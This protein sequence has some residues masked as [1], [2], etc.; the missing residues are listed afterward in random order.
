MS[1]ITPTVGRKVW[2]FWDNRQTEPQDATIIKVMEADPSALVNLHVVHPDTGG[3]E[4]ITRVRAGDESTVWPHYRWMPYQKGQAAKAEADAAN[5]S[6]IDAE[7][8]EQAIQARGSKGPRVTQA[9]I[10]ANIASE[11]Y[12]TAEDGVR[13]ADFPMTQAKLPRSLSLLTICVLELRNGFNVVGMSACASPENF[14][15]DIG[16]QYAYRDAVRQVWPLLGFRLMD[17]LA[18]EAWEQAN[19]ANPEPRSG[20]L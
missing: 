10:E 18:R 2:F 15:A 17:R 12:F 4:L 16:R 14:D 20:P 1:T 8:L 9:D 13:G 5:T 6:S 3:T 11:H 19:P 7:Q